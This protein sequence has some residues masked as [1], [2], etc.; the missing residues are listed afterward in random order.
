MH[1]S[2]AKGKIRSMISED[3]ESRCKI[4]AC[5]AFSLCLRILA[6]E[7]TTQETLQ[8]SLYPL[9]FTVSA[10]MSCIESLLRPISSRPATWFET[11]GNAVRHVAKAQLQQAFHKP[12]VCTRNATRPFGLSQRRESIPLRK[13]FKSDLASQPRLGVAMWYLGQA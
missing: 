8:H 4:D 5:D 6:M 3:L 2:G 7:I 1:E 12:I 11:T 9:P 10:H 13:T